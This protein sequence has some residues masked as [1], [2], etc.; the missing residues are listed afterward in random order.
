MTDAQGH[1]EDEPGRWREIFIGRLG[2]YT[3]IL[4][5]GMAVFAINHFVV[6]TIMPTVVADIGGLD[7]YTWAFSL[8]AVGSIIGAASAGPISSAYGMRRV[9]AGAGLLMGLGL[10]GNAMAWDMQSVVAF[11][12]VQGVGGGAVASLAYGLVAVLYPHNLRS[13]V[14]AIV[15]GIWGFGTLSG[16]AVGG[17]FAEPGLW[18][19]SFWTMMG[20]ALAFAVLAWRYVDG[21]KKGGKLSDLPFWRLSMLAL[22]VLLMSATSL[23]DRDAWRIGLFVL[24]VIIAGAAFHRDARSV[25]NMFPR[26]ITA[27][28]SQLGA[29]YWVLFLVSIVITAHNTYTTYYL[30]LLHGV[31]PLTAGYILAAQSMMWT[32]SALGLSGAKRDQEPYLIAAGLLCMLVASVGIALSLEHGPVAIIAG[33]LGLSGF[34]MGLLNIPAMQ[35]VITAAAE[36]DKQLAGISVQTVRNIGI[37]F[38]AALT[39][40]VAAM[41][42]L[43]DNSSVAEVVH[44][45][46]WVYGVNIGFALLSFLAVIPVFIHRHDPPGST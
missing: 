43:T 6:S 18:R 9:Y 36:A 27:I 29:S 38:G 13:R 32:V 19:G 25:R 33:C 23:A 12:L 34:G 22:S 37:S 44:A 24:A 2:V 31:A 45:M 10:A 46:H 21:E 16:P 20:F 42:G 11:R 39:G 28:M 3:L 41:A 17:F 4:N 5:L 40:M 26:G 35:R 1:A 15:S 14:L 8:F 7:F 30:Q